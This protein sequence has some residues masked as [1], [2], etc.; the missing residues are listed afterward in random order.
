MTNSRPS[1]ANGAD[2]AD[3]PHT[4]PRADF[5]DLRAPTDVAALRA[6]VRE[7]E[8]RVRRLEEQ[9][10]AGPACQRGSTSVR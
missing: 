2:L 3:R 10:A 8:E 7:L 9:L 6:R 5:V 4:D 1:H